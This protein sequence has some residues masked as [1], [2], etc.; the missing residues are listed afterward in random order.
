MVRGALPT[1][2]TVDITAMPFG[3]HPAD[4]NGTHPAEGGTVWLRVTSDDAGDWP[5]DGWFPCPGTF[6][7]IR[8]AIDNK[9][10]F[11]RGVHS[12]MAAYWEQYARHLEIAVRQATEY[13]ENQ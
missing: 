11:V 3:V 6:G 5:Y 12:V 2:D 1:G 7:A 8:N 4:S 9:G 13:I 10:G